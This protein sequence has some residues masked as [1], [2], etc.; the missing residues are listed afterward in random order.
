MNLKLNFNG[1]TLLKDWWKIML[2]NLTTINTRFEAHRTTYPMDHPNKS[3]QKNH[4]ADKAVGTDQLDDYSVTATKLAQY[5]VSAAKIYPG[6]VQTAHIKDVNITK[7]K[8]EQSLQEQ[9]DSFQEYIDSPP[10][11]ADGSVTWDKINMNVQPF[12][13]NSMNEQETYDYCQ[14]NFSNAYSNALVLMFNSSYG[15]FTNAPPDTAAMSD[16][17]IKFVMFTARI[18]AMSRLQIAINLSSMKRYMRIVGGSLAHSWREM[19]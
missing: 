3:V 19:S 6:A 7:A 16:G 5:S 12:I 9:L 13:R 11:V 10:E 18:S 4:I 8:L 17:N 14:N 2:E 15:S 1:K